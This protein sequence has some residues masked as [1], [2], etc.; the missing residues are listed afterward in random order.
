VRQR[1]SRLLQTTR[2]AVVFPQPPEHVVKTY[3]L[4]CYKGAA[5]A[6]VM[7]NVTDALLD[8]FV[9]DCRNGW[10]ELSPMIC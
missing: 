3:Q 7:P 4:A 10:R 1:H 6:I 8:A 5:H 2:I 9:H